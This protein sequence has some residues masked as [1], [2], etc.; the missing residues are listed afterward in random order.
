MTGLDVDPE[1]HKNTPLALQ[2]LLEHVQTAIPEGVEYRKHVESY[3]NRM[4]KIIADSPSQSDAEQFLARQFEQIQQDVDSE[5]TVIKSMAEWKPWETQG[6]PA[7]K[8]FAEYKNMPENV[9][10]FREF[11]HALG[12]SERS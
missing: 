10:Q 11:Q 4:L 1:A 8:V 3:C 6:V 7:P 2:D 5:M 9:R 12:T